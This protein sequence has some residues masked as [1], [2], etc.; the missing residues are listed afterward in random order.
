MESS[1]DDISWLTQVPSLDSQ[2]A[3]S[4]VIVDYVEDDIPLELSNNV[5]SLEESSQKV[6]VL[7]DNV[8]AENISSDDCVDNM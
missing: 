1:D 5:V 8:I 6:Q 3:N 2:V 4:G 7:Y